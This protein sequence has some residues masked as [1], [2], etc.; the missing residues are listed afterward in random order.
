VH[1]CRAAAD[2][3]GWRRSP[4][5]KTL[6]AGSLDD[7]A[8]AVAGYVAR[9]IFARDRTVPPWS[10]SATDGAD[11]AALLRARQVRGYPECSG[12]IHDA[13][14]KQIEILEETA[15]RDLCAGIVRY[16]LAQLYE[17]CG[18]R[19]PVEAL[20]LHAANREQYPRFYRGRYRLAISLQ[21]LANPHPAEV[22]RRTA[23]QAAAT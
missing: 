4:A 20:L 22:P 18:T 21:M 13:W 1:S 8:S 16:E 14:D 7:A 12:D 6:V 17:I 10:T 19:R 3:A 15:G 9:H 23:Y 2:P 11:L 5:P